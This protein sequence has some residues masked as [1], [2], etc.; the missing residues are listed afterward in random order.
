MGLI[1]RLI[2]PDFDMSILFSFLVRRYFIQLIEFTRLAIERPCV[3]I[4]GKI[5]E[6]GK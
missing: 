3:Q 4:S 6:P 2:S 5:S 1:S